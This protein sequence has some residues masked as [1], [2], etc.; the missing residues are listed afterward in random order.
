MCY[1]YITVRKRL[2]SV[3][4]REDRTQL[5]QTLPTKVY[6]HE[7]VFGKFHTNQSL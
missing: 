6:F 4:L 3:F 1:L 2:S 5:G 7:A